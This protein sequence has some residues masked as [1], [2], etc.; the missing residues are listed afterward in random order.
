MNKSA[1]ISSGSSSTKESSA[2]AQSQNSKGTSG[3]NANF[4]PN[5]IN[6]LKEER[7]AML[8]SNL[9]NTSAVM[10]DDMTGWHTICKWSKQFW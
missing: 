1:N 7:K 5:V 8:F 9:N 10:L 6:K 3:A 4:W 2:G